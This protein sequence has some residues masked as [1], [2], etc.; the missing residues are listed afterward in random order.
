M[1]NHTAEDALRLVPED[2]SRAVESLMHVYQGNHDHLP[3]LLSHA[4]TLALKMGRRLTTRQLL[5]IGGLLAVGA[6]L[7]IRQVTDDSED[8]A[9]DEKDDKKRVGSRNGEHRAASHDKP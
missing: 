8:E 5:I 6:L 2:L 3:E 9:E 7:A 1:D 4:G